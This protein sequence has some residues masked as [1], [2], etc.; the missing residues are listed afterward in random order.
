MSYMNE[1]SKNNSAIRRQLEQNALN[2]RRPL[3][4]GNKALVAILPVPELSTIALN[5]GNVSGSPSKLENFERKLSQAQRTDLNNSAISG[6]K[7]LPPISDSLT[8]SA[9]KVKQ[10]TGTSK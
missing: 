10:T 6:K 2:V 7:Q 5:N 4:D 1:A 9:I 8:T 3:G